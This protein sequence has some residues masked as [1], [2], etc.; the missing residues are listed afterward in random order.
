[1]PPSSTKREA[2][3]GGTKSQPGYGCASSQG[4]WSRTDWTPEATIWPSSPFTSNPGLRNGPSATMP[5]K[6]GGT[7]ACA[8]PGLARAA[9]ASVIP[10]AFLSIASSTPAEL[11]QSARER[12]RIGIDTEFVSEGRYRA[13]LCLVQV[14]VDAPGGGSRVEILD[15]IEGFDHEP[16]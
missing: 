2:W 5:T 13:L 7:A 3:S 11:A 15:P 6:F 16:I 1:M 4:N 10:R 14:A 8:S 9:A 12:G